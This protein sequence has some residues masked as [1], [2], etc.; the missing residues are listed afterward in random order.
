[1]KMHCAKVSCVFEYFD[2]I[3][4]LLH[5]Q[6]EFLQRYIFVKFHIFQAYLPNEAESELEFGFMRVKCLEC[7]PKEEQYLVERKLLIKWVR[8]GVNSFFHTYTWIN[9]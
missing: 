8:K 1:M 7:I 6:K 9:Q 2:K 5:N 4:P 3:I